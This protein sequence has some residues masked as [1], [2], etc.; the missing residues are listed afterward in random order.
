[1]KSDFKVSNSWDFETEICVN[2]A[3]LFCTCVL[4]TL[5]FKISEFWVQVPP[6]NQSDCAL[7]RWGWAYG[8]QGPTEDSPY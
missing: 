8:L 6:P 4:A 2:L 3:F 7:S 1:M 5:I